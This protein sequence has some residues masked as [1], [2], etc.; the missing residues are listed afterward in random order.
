MIASMTEHPAFI[1][2]RRTDVLA[3]NTLAR[4]LL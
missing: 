3:S 4:A 2:G 1:I